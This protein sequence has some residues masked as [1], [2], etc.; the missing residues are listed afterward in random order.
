MKRGLRNNHCQDNKR[1]PG[2]FPA[3]QK[4][5]TSRCH[6][7]YSQVVLKITYLALSGERQ[8]KSWLEGEGGVWA[9]T[10]KH[11]TKDSLG[12][13]CARPASF[14]EFAHP[15]VTGIEFINSPAVLRHSEIFP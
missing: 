6:D 15:L 7:S 3:S 10:T 9:G 8:G 12:G 5:L 2:Y 4:T 13:K 1:K 11:T 14:L